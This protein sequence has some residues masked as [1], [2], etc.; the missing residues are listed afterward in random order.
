VS[1]VCSIDWLL[2]R[3]RQAGRSTALVWHDKPF[4]YEWLLT[5]ASALRKVL[6]E[7]GIAAGTVVALDAKY[8]ADTAAALLALIAENAV[9]VMLSSTSQLPLQRIHEVAEV[10]MVVEFGGPSATDECR[11][12]PTG[13]AVTNP[14]TLRLVASGNP[15]LV[16]FSSGST[17]TSKG[18]VLDF[19]RLLEKFKVQKPPMV[20]LNFLLLDHIGGI[21]TLF[22][23]LSSLGT[24]V[25]ASS[26]APDEVAA[27]IAKHKVELLPT[28]P[29][30]LN[31]LLASEAYKRHDLSSLKRIAYGTEA[32][33][34]FTLRR[35]REAL[36]GVV[37]QQTYGLTELGVLRSRSRDSDSLWVKLGGEGIETEVRD[38]VLWVRSKSAMLGYLNAP[39][40]FD[41]E[42]WMN[43]EDVVEVEGEW[44]RIHGRK[45][46]IINV[47]GQKVYPAEVESVLLQLENVKD[48]TVY[49]EANPI[50][51]KIVAAC[52]ELASEEPLESFKQRMRAFCKER[53]APY[54][55]PVRIQLTG[56]PQ[57]SA[58][59][60]KMRRR[61]AT[62]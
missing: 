38:G 2:E 35:L 54:K 49:G 1:G 52:V 36:P 45:S 32:M 43:T 25:M 5:R 57:F 16:L 4:T 33:P 34:E 61:L 50:T 27:A 20:T 53:L 21:D 6:R 46:D 62:Q 9:V 56:D 15:G 11:V 48:V 17:G 44:M 31:L 19:A 10:Q 3:M 23:T 24:V 59:F 47:G 14:L 55:V 41:E 28:S 13:R 8:S 12:L 37:L 39:S 29:T 7:Q 58:R 30:F 51:G 42:G 18:A 26:R 60:K 22:Y 40:P